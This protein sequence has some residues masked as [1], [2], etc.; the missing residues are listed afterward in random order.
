MS[1]EQHN[2]ET[3]WIEIQIKY[4]KPILL[5][6]LYRNPAERID[7]IDRFISMMDHAHNQTNDIIILGDFNI[8]L[9]KDNNQWNLTF[10]SFGLI[11]LIKTPTRVTNISKTLIDHLYVSDPKTVIE[12]NVPVCGCSDHFPICFT[13]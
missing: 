4:C 7:W 1:L 5:C 8:D 11:Q 12:T 13:W 2:V 6:F 3:V 9:L 10:K